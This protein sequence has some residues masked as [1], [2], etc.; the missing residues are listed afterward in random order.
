MKKFIPNHQ[1]RTKP[2]IPHAIIEWLIDDIE[3][4][5][6]HRK[7][8]RKFKISL[9]FA[10]LR[11]AKVLATALRFA[12]FL[13]FS[14][15]ELLRLRVNHVMDENQTVRGTISFDGEQINIENMGRSIAE[16][17]SYLKTIYG[18]KFQPDS[19]LFPDMKKKKSYKKLAYDESTL[20][21]HINYFS[22]VTGYDITIEKIR[23]SGIC[24]FYDLL[25]ATQPGEWV[26]ELALEAT[27]K[28]ARVKSTRH[29]YNIL[30]DRIDP[31]G[32]R[33]KPRVAQPVVIPTEAVIE[34]IRG[35]GSLSAA[36]AMVIIENDLPKAQRSLSKME[37][38]R[39]EFIR[40]ISGDP[41][42]DGSVKE[43]LVEKFDAQLESIGFRVNPDDGRLSPPEDVL[44]ED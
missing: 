26:Q 27:A 41:S 4:G 8:L 13:G 14:T 18:K 23:Q 12:Y 33:P 6:D 40:V 24:R 11:N 43:T 38:L 17:C 22:E 37:E 44:Y 9:N 35:V 42:L 36:E 3:H 1:I 25:G 16:Y 39:N 28:F 32:N 20:V 10:Y 15:G 30:I 31:W 21:R 29:A 5:Q 19:P 7:L 2:P 34:R